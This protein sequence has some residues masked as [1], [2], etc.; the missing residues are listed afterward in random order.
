MLKVEVKESVLLGING[1]NQG[2]AMDQRFEGNGGGR[3]KGCSLDQ[4]G[5]FACVA[6]VKAW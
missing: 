3:R 5:N 1:R 4:R 6:I 2:T